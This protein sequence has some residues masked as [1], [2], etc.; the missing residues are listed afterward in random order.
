VR[1]RFHEQAADDLAEDVR[2]Y[3]DASPGLGLRFLAEARAAVRVVERH[4]RLAALVAEGIHAKHLIRFPHTLLYAVERGE[5][6]IL[7][8]AHQRQDLS[9]WIEIVRSRHAG[10]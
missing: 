1:S 10:A 3:N 2:Y 6:V 5:L 9:R 7:A 4:P 8:V